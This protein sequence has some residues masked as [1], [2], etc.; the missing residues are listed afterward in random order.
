MFTPEVISTGPVRLRLPRE[1]DADAITRA[2][3]DPLITRFIAGAPVPYVRDDALAFVKTAAQSWDLG[4]AQFA[5]AD[6]ETDE[7]LGGAGL[8]PVD[9]QGTYSIGYLVAPWARGRGVASAAARALTEWAFEHGA[10][11]MELLAD[12][13][14]VASQRVAHAAGFQR[15]GVRRGWEPRRD[16]L[17]H[18]MAAFARLSGDAG[19]PIRPYLPFLPGGSLTD[20][21]VRLTPITVADATGFHE[22]LSDPDVQKYHVPPEAP[23]FDDLVARCRKTGMWWLAGERAEM[24]VLDAGTGE[25]AG[26][27]QLAQV[28]PGLGQAMLGYSLLAAFRGRGFATRAVNL[29][30]RWTFEHTELARVIAGTDPGNA[31]SHRVLE[32]TG[33]AREA[34]L[35][36]FLPGPGGVRKDD[37]Q[38]VH[39]RP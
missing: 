27:I 35:R 19:H 34:L 15:E 25:F 38:W 6:P 8:K 9:G 22:M 10:A 4:G 21:V 33:F 30:I 17:R 16:G 26:H 32:R 37:L 5:V 23:P 11:R 36:D 14:N 20:G 3:T 12:I 1:D 2:F 7:W 18:D 39:L 28:L 13:E 24:A 29:L 31:A